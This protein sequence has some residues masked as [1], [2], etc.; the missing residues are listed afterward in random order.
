MRRAKKPPPTAAQ[1][2][3]VRALVKRRKALTRQIE[4]ANRKIDDANFEIAELTVR[5]SAWRNVCVR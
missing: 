2:K 3:R 4:D 5:T 1:R